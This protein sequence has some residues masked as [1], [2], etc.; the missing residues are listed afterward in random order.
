MGPIP[1]CST[2]YP[3]PCESYGHPGKWYC[4][5]CNCADAGDAKPCMLNEEKECAEECGYTLDGSPEGNTCGFCGAGACCKLG[6]IVGDSVCNGTVGGDVHICVRETPSIDWYYPC[7]CASACQ[8]YSPGSVE[9]CVKHCKSDICQRLEDGTYDLS[10]CE[11]YHRNDPHSAHRFAMTRQKCNNLGVLAAIV[12]LPTCCVC[13]CACCITAI[14]ACVCQRKKTPAAASSALARLQAYLAYLDPASGVPVSVPGSAL[15][16]VSGV[17]VS[18]PYTA[19]TTAEP[20]ADKWICICGYSNTGSK[21]C[22]SCGQKKADL[23]DCSCGS[24]NKSNFCLDCGKAK[25]ARASGFR[26]LTCGAPNEDTK[27]CTSCGTAAPSDTFLSGTA[28][29]QELQ[30]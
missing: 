13:C 14:T 9:T 8:E 23:W 24:L 6:M 27:F 26:C 29:S 7:D 12:L 21:F 28:E 4:N 20:A 3:Y 15:H 16:P 19:A 1:D 30:S 22:T 17:P 10:Y 11:N 25:P 18:V 2:A 5:E